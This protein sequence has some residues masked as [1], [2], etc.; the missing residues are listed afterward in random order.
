MA[1]R[2]AGR[3]MAVAAL[4]LQVPRRGC[5]IIAGEFSGG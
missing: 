1:S 4:A 5:K 3:A 2:L